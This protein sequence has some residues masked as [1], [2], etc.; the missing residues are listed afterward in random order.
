MNKVG[1]IAISILG[2]AIVLTY[3]LATFGL[4]HSAT[5]LTRTLVFAIGPVAIIG[6]LGISSQL[7]QK[8]GSLT[9]SSA[10]AFLVIAFSMFTLMTIMQQAFQI[11]FH[12]LR[13]YT[14]DSIEMNLLQSMYGL[15]NQVQLGIDVCF[16]VFYCL[17]MILISIVMYH[18]KD[19]G[20]II[21]VSGTVIAAAL[22]T[23]N[24]IAFP[25][26]PAGSGLIDL[27]PVSGIWWIIVI[28]LSIRGQRRVLAN[29]TSQ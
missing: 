4:I 18:H 20:R 9:H 25:H 12:E 10:T 16:D 7:T 5:L 17:G 26:P 21:A 6:M 8:G 1:T 15:V 14:K 28:I 23:L 13:Q 2:L 29:E 3:L 24:L 19:F 27:G 22:L 11:H